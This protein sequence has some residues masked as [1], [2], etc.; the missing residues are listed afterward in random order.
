[1]NAPKRLYGPYRGVVVSTRDPLNAGRIQAQVPKVFGTSTTGWISPKQTAGLPLVIPNLGGGVWIEF[2]GGDPSYP[3]WTGTFGTRD[4]RVIVLDDLSDV[5]T[6]VPAEGQVLTYDAVTGHWESRQLP[7]Q[8]NELDDLTDVAVPAPANND[9]LRYNS[10]TGEWG[11]SDLESILPA[12]AINDTFVIASQAAMLSLIAQKGDLAIRTDVT[13]SFVLAAS[14]AT[15]LANWKELLTPADGVTSVNGNAGPAVT[16][17]AGDITTG[18]FSSAQLPAITL[19]SLSDVATASA[20]AN[21]SLVYN[22]NSWVAGVTGRGMIIGSIFLWF[23]AV[24]SPAVLALEGQTIT[25]GVALYPELAA[26][27]PDWVSGANL[28]LPDARGRVFVGRDTGQV[29]FDVLGEVGG[30][31]TVSLTANQNGT[32]T[33]TQN[34]HNHTQ[35]SH[36]HSQNSHNHTQ[37][38]HNHSQNSHNHTQNSHNHSQ[39]A[40]AHSFK[41]GSHTIYWGNNGGATVYFSNSLATGGSAPSNN[42]S[43]I[44][45]TW[46]ESNTNTATNNATTATNQATTATN[47]ATT[48][49]NQATTATNNATTA[50]NQATT[51]TNQNSGLGEAHNNLQPYLVGRYV[52]AVA[53]GA[54]GPQGPVGATGTTGA[55][56]ATGAQGA[57]STVPGP[58]GPSGTITGATSTALSAGATPTVTLGGTAEARTFAFGIPVGATGAQGVTGDTG[59]TGPS[60]TI[61]SATATGLAV[62]AA[63]TITLGG[64]PEARTFAFGIPV[65]AT[66]A[67]GA[68]GEQGPQGVPGSNLVSSVAGRQGV[69]VL[70]KN[71]VGL[72]NVDNTSDADKPVST[73]QQTAIQ[74]GPTTLFGGTP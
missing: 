55:T 28:I 7:P 16:L 68:T 26:I 15:T 44:Q 67:T 57:A 24:L 73:A 18:V 41:G 51:A 33:H 29:E 59:A 69:V 31:K 3:L 9:V 58:V 49:T 8:A 2:E 56:G 23:S 50:T 17:G 22:G 27:Y 42:P 37:D 46:A 53:G 10:A 1:M 20:V 12:I 63:P 43:L 4:S 14:P 74:N 6:G 40:H 36:N 48:A 70:A 13:K 30:A 66:G 47:N 5:E 34:S 64:T 11:S 61:T 35:D 54:T 19:D 71:D 45:G 21:D 62:G 65:G 32:H 39:N 52:V 25:G 60:G 72:A 38:S